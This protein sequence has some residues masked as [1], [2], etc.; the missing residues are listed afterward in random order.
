MIQLG[1]E[2]C[3]SKWISAQALGGKSIES[4]GT[5]FVLISVASFSHQARMASHIIIDR[6]EKLL[7]DRLIDGMCLI[8]AFP[9]SGVCGDNLSVLLV[10]EI[11]LNIYLEFSSLA[12]CVDTSVSVI[13]VI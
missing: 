10:W 11:F 13:L 3:W 6:S 4:S 7:L 5:L 12:L 1:V 9:F 2:F 8:S